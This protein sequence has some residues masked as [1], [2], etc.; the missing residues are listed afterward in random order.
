MKVK[1]KAN[2]REID[3]DYDHYADVLKGQ[4]WDVVDKAPQESIEV[5]KV[6]PEP[7]K[8]TTKKKAAPKRKYKLKSKK[9]DV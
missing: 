1:N 2:G 7:P 9:D 5:N 8:A 4:G 3:V 6:A